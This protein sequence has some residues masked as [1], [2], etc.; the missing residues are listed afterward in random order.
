MTDDYLMKQIGVFIRFHRMNQ[1]KTQAI[2]SQ[3]AGISR[4]T[5]SLLE[6]GKTVTLLSFIQVLRTLKLLDIMENFNTHIEISPILLAKAERK[7]RKRASKVKIKASRKSS[8]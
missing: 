7:N 5:L 2:I 4:S 3:K 6:N 8:W 1:N